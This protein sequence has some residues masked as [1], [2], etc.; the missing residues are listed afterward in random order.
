M[1]FFDRSIECANKIQKRIRVPSEQ[2]G[3]DRNI[4]VNNSYSGYY[5]GNGN[6]KIYKNGRE[7][8][9]SSIPDFAKQN[10]WFLIVHFKTANMRFSFS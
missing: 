3:T 4:Y 10:L 5:L 7:V 2:G 6:N 9:S 8:S 1:A